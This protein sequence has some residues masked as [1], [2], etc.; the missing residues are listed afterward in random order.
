MKVTSEALH[1]LYDG[2]Y[3]NELPLKKWFTMVT[4]K[5][6]SIHSINQTT[7]DRDK[8]VEILEKN[9]YSLIAKNTVDK[10]VRFSDGEVYGYFNEKLNIVAELTIYYSNEDEMVKSHLSFIYNSQDHTDMG[11]YVD[12]L[13]IFS[14]ENI[15]EKKKSNIYLLRSVQG[16]VDIEGYDLKVGEIDIESNYGVDFLKKHDKIVEKLNE[17]KGKGIVLFHGEPGSG[18]TTYIRHLTHMIEGKKVIFIPPSLTEGLSDPSFI[19][20]LMQHP[21]SILVIED[22]ERVIG[23]RSSG[24]VSSA[25][26]SNILNLT[27]G[28]LSDCL[29][30]QIVVTFNMDKKEIDSALLRKGRLIVEHKFGVLTKAD[31]QK[32]IDKLGKNYVA[33]QGMVL[34]DIYN[35]EEEVYRTEEK[36]IGF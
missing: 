19:P 5:L 12:D 30:I 28:I 13:G 4:N 26:V 3:N 22:G 10:L 16:G 27:D 34:S 32:L 20:F 14:V 25:G 33:H 6:P 18:K 1:Q 8:I 2:V 24:N 23:N 15:I 31:T 21:N 36:K 29:N 9:S 17:D 35:I 11:K 7:F